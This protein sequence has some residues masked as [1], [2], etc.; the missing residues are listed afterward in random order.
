MSIIIKIGG[1]SSFPPCPLPRTPIYAFFNVSLHNSSERKC[2]QWTSGKSYSCAYFMTQRG[3][4]WKVYETAGKTLFL[5]GKVKLMTSAQKNATLVKWK[6]GLIKYWSRTV[7]YSSRPTQ[8]IILRTIII[9]YMQV[10][11]DW[12]R[13]ITMKFLKFFSWSKYLQVIMTTHVR[14]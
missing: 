1:G 10:G 6:T 5:S 7:R 14:T 13:K 8:L 2:I 12:K 9:P 11:S 4:P 3:K